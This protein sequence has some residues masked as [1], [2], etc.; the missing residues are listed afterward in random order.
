MRNLGLSAVRA[1]CHPLPVCLPRVVQGV[2]V[3][4]QMIGVAVA[5]G[6]EAGIAA[7]GAV[8]SGVAGVGAAIVAAAPACPV[9]G[10]RPLPEHPNCG[11]AGKGCVPWLLGWSANKMYTFFLCAH[12]RA[13]GGVL[14]LGGAREPSPPRRPAPSL[15]APLP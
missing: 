12:E 6:G 15:A 5:A 4:V 13:V 7:G 3:V 14:N 2:G 1:A 11:R 10:I 8:G 9:C